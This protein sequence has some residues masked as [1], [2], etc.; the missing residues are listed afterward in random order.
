MS[1]GQNACGLY[2]V[3]G[4]GDDGT[5]VIVPLRCRRWWCPSCGP[6]LRDRLVRRIASEDANALLTL[7]CNPRAYAS[8]EEAFR[9]L[10]VAVNSLFK[11]IRRLVHPA[12]VEYFLVW[13]L[14]KAGWPHAHVILRGP[15]VSQTWLSVA[16]SELSGAYIVDIRGIHQ[17]QAAMAYVAK[18][19][20]KEPQVPQ[21]MKR[22]RSS[23]GFFAHPDLRSE[24][25]LKGLSN[26]RIIPRTT[27][28]IARELAGRGYA[29][30]RHWDGSI[31]ATPP[32]LH[33]FTQ[34]D[35]GPD[36]PGKPP[37]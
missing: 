20:A 13:E 33:R 31:T 19:L 1:I 10:S 9:G 15:F 4:D 3:Q 21:G 30:L 6:F 35:P 14:T 5:A 25:R 32:S 36:P 22:Y 11:R 17:A 28:D 24:R 27:S 34:L 16:W 26:I 8:P 2:S 37:P 23:R 29:I 12:P 7:T 18:Y